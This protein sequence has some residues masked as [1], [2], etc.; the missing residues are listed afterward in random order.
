[1]FGNIAVSSDCPCEIVADHEVS[2]RLPCNAINLYA[3]RHKVPVHAFRQ[4]DHFGRQV[5]L[6]E[7]ASFG[8]KCSL[9]Q[10]IC[11]KEGMAVPNPKMRGPEGHSPAALGVQVV[12]ISWS[13]P[14]AAQ[15]FL[16]DARRLRILKPRR[17][18][19]NPEKQSQHLWSNIAFCRASVFADATRRL[20]VRYWKVASHD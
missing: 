20:K 9:G 6:N 15:M 2:T 19:Q 18:G 1:M 7:I 4:Q 11:T 8:D 12:L 10:R 14:Y 5:C 16:H 13:S 17:C 3:A